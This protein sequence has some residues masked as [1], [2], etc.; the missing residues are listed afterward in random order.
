VLSTADC[1]KAGGTS[2]TGA[3]PTCSG[4]TCP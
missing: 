3:A 1:T 2:T 4:V